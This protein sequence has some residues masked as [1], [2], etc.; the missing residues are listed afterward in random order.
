MQLLVLQGCAMCRP[1]AEAEEG[2]KKSEEEAKAEQ[3]ALAQEQTA[4]P[5]EGPRPDHCECRYSD[6][7]LHEALATRCSRGTLGMIS[8]PL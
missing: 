6:S 2:K 5:E 7:A 3:E 1:A 4:A 8:C